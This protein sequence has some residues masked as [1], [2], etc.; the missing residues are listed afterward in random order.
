MENRIVVALVSVGVG[1]L[2]GGVVNAVTS[3]YA[4]FKEAQGIAASLQ[5]EIGSITE[6]VKLRNYLGLI[7]TIVGRLQSPGYTPSEI[8][9]FSPRVGLEYFRVFASTCSKI[10][11]LGEAGP[12][13]VR[14]YMLAQSVIEDFSRLADDRRSVED[15]RRT[16]NRDGLLKNTLELR[17]VLVAALSSADEATRALSKFAASWWICPAALG[18]LKRLQLTNLRGP[19]TS[20]KQLVQCVSVVWLAL[21][22]IG[23]LITLYGPFYMYTQS[24]DEIGGPPAI[25]PIYLFGVLSL[26]VGMIGQWFARR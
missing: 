14:A 18:G 19:C 11:L 16:A 20:L 8:D 6:L 15:E 9:F 3:E 17:G 24:V 13:T 2:L 21:S 5:R 22:I 4:T 12:P 23:A 26:V 7:D 10:G 1:A 25:R